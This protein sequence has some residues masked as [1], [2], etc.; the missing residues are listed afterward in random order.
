MNAVTYYVGYRIACVHWETH[1]PYES[2]SMY[3]IPDDIRKL[4][5]DIDVTLNLSGCL[6]DELP[7][8]RTTKL[9][10]TCVQE[11]AHGNGS[12]RFHV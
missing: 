4:R 10:V 8:L 6:V 1:I 11:D 2:A 3:I 9:Q 12:G 5:A 7:D